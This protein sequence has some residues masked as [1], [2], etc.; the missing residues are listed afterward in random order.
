MYLFASI[1]PTLALFDWLIKGSIAVWLF[2]FVGVN[3]IAIISITTI[4]WLLNVALPGI[5]GGFFVLKFKPVD[6]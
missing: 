3:E 2:G 5:V 1:I 6:V 4:M